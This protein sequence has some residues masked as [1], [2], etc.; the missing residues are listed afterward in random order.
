MIE[1]QD[2]Y[3]LEKDGS[4]YSNR[5]FSK[6]TKLEQ[7]IDK[8]GYLRVTIGNPRVIHK[9]HRLVAQTFISNPENKPHVNHIDGNK[10]NNHVD[11]LEWCTA[12]ENIQHAYDTGLKKPYK[13]LKD[14]GNNEF[15]KEWDKL[16]KNGESMRSIGKRYGV[17]HRTVGNVVKKYNNLKIK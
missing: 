12:S 10:T 8:G 17:S 3:F 11:S 5:K 15:Y 7:H 13:G 2:G 14:K 4:V 9:V 6:K 1:I 16:I